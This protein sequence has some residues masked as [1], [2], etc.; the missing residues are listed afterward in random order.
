[1]TRLAK[2]YSLS[3]VIVTMAFACRQK[4]AKLT[5]ADS[6]MVKDS[7]VKLMVNIENDISAKGPAAWLNY[8]D[9]SPGFFMASDGKIAFASYPSA[10]KFVLD[11]LVKIIPRI[12]LVWSNVKAVALANDAVF[13]AAGFNED[14]TDTKGLT[15]HT[16][17]YF[18]AISGL[19]DGRWKLK[20][21]HW[22]ISH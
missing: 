8:F 21:L 22:S 3:I 19:N 14:L 1:M 2:Q 15:Q 20:N 17:G 16:H 6:A 5:P 4:I 9:D 10:R 12:K 18:T 13:I 11:T 7:A